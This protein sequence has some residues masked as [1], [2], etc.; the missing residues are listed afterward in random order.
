[1][2]YIGKFGLYEIKINYK[3][4]TFDRILKHIRKLDIKDIR[5][6]EKA[7]IEKLNKG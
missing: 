3:E 1:M 6:E 4:L 2:I 5:E 7:Y